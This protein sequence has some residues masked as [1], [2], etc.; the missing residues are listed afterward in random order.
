MRPTFKQR[1]LVNLQEAVESDL[2][3]VLASANNAVAAATHAENRPENKY[4]TRG[5]EASYLAGAQNARA[6]ELT[7]TLEVIKELAPRDFAP[8]DMIS[9]TAV[10][11]L[12]CSGVTSFYF[13]LGVAAG[14]V[15]EV[16]GKLVR[17]LT[18]NAP[19]AAALMGKFM[20]EIIEV[21][22]GGELKEY[23]IIDVL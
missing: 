10:V 4:D 11:E 7:A 5:L 21:L 19:V 20:G 6:A 17:T 12:K 23:E 3:N 2:K 22:V 14:Y 13:L 16:D 8:E 15:L 1:L 18:P 9:V